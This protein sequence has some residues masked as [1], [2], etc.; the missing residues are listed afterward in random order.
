MKY[1][2][3]LSGLLAIILTFIYLG[4]GIYND[5][6]VTQTHYDI[7][8]EK[9]I[10][11]ERLRI[12]QITDSHLGTTFDGIGF[13]EHLDEIQKTNP[14]L[15]V[16]TGDYVDDGTSKKDMLAATE[17]LGKFQSTYGTY[18]IFGNHD[19]GYFNYRDF[20]EQELRSALK[21]NN[22]TILEDESILID[23]RFYITGRQD[24]TEDH[25][26]SAEALASELDGTKYD[27]VLDHQPND[28]AAES[29][30]GMDLVLSGHTHGGQVF[31]VNL[32]V[33]RANDRVYGHEKRGSTDFI[34]S[35][36]ISDWEIIFKT[37]TFSEFCV[38]DITRG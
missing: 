11:G 8:T 20:T 24:K 37:G 4:F 28:Y 7:A 30:A 17:A 35:S 21:K 12:A 29:A 33:G 6:H 19:K 1:P 34:V 31:P 3:Y 14:D 16:I 5:F 27:I 10:G 9:D 36:G 32:F 26:K 25:R 2:L 13:S 18:F 22:V 38:I 15:L 23:N